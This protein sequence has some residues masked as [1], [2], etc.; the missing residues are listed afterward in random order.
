M[1]TF[2][3]KGALPCLYCCFQTMQKSFFLTF[4]WA[5]NIALK[6]RTETSNNYLQEDLS[7]VHFWFCLKE[8]LEKFEEL[9]Q[10][11]S[12]CNPPPSLPSATTENS[13]QSRC[14]YLSFS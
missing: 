1:F 7:M 2:Q 12:R 3:P 13:K 14:C 11:F 5:Q 4:T 8:G 9:R 6:F 10:N